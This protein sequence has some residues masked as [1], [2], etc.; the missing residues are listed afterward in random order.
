[1]N[2]LDG[3]ENRGRKGIAYAWEDLY[4]ASQAATLDQQIAALRLE[5][6]E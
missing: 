5:Y 3:T 4:V 2:E 1:M 6:A